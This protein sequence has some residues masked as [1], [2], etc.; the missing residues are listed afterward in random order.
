V[1]RGR[2][3]PWPAP[4]RLAEQDPGLDQA[5]HA[6]LDEERI[7]AGPVTEEALERLQRAVGAEQGVEQL[8]D[9]L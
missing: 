6:L 2:P 1:L 8:V 9:A 7:L 5:P 4:A 3:A